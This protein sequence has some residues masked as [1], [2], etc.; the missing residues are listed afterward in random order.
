[1]QNQGVDAYISV[2]VPQ[3]DDEGDRQ[4]EEILMSLGAWIR[5]Q[6]TSEEGKERLNFPHELRLC[7]DDD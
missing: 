1:M 6:E 2:P 4:R 5:G 7:L 3:T